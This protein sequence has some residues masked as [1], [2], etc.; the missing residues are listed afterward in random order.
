[1]VVNIAFF[2]VKHRFKIALLFALA[3]AGAHYA[4][5]RYLT[6]KLELT[7]FQRDQNAAQLQSCVK[8]HLINRE[9]SHE[10]QT[11][12]SDI[13][14]RLS[15]LKRVRGQASCIP[16]VTAGGSD[17][18]GTGTELPGRN[19]LSDLWLL[20][21]AARCDKSRVKATGLQS[22]IRRNED[23]AF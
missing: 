21:F 8:Q 5:A 20:E 13:D 22:L 16:V 11:Q 7:A 4:H 14:R 23:G 6:S 9:V 19:G 10:Y 2:L 12:L 3:L 15:D 1:M 18:T 17:G